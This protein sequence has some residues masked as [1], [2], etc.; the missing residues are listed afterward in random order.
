MRKFMDLLE[1]EMG[2][3]LKFLLPAFLVMAVL[4]LFTTFQTILEFNDYSKQML[5]QGQEISSLQP[6][7]AV[8]ITQRGLFGVSMLAIVLV[9]I[10]YSF[11]TWYREWLGKNAFIYRLLMLPLNRTTIYLTKALVFLLGGF[12]SFVFQFGMYGL[13]LFLSKS[14]VQPELY[15]ALNIHQIRPPFDW[16]QHALFPESGIQFLS[17]YGFAFAALLTLFTAILLERSYRWKGLIAGIVY[18]IGY[19]VLYSLVSVSNHLRF[20]PFI[21]R[22]SHAYLASIVYFFVVI[23]VGTAIS[24]RLLKNKVKV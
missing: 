1:F 4:Q 21:T 16:I 17:T 20:I 7:T 14:M 13:V 23:A 10:F 11:F 22:P 6:F 9:F 8:N 15:Q 2:R 12:L 24:S 19:F 18:F 5:A 3:F